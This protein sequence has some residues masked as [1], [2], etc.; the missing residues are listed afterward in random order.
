MLSFEPELERLR[1]RLGDTITGALIA[2]ERREVFS[3]HPELRICAWGGAM[4]LATAAG[5]ILFKNFERIGPLALATLIGAAAVACYAFVWFRRARAS[6]VD[7]YVLLLG[8]LL[9][10]ADAAFIELQFHLFG[11]HPY[12]QFLVAGAIHGITAYLFRSRMLLSLSIAAVAAWLGVWENELWRLDSRELSL[13]L[14]GCLCI[15]AVWRV[16]NRRAEFAP[17]LEQFGVNFLLLSTTTLM[18]DDTLRLGVACPLTI[19]FA[20]AVIVWGFRERRESL[21][22]YGFL[23]GLIAV[24]VLLIDP[25]DSE[26]FGFAVVVVSIVA[27]IAGLFAIHARF[28]ELRA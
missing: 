24:D 4:F 28:R 11:E 14:F 21:V 26:K 1:P 3:L 19:F 17:V 6:L 18:G 2:R 9:V 15:V 13:R 27:A 20:T 8:A 22:L 7:D 25:F 12:R 16:A 10:S 5:V 23:Y